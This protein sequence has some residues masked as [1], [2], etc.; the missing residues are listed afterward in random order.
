M[1]ESAVKEADRPG[2]T[3]RRPRRPIWPIVVGAS[4]IVGLLAGGIITLSNTH[5]A[6]LPKAPENLTAAART[7]MP[8]A[9]GAILS[10]VT[11]RW[12]LPE[13]PSATGLQ[14]LRDGTTLPAAAGLLPGTTG[15]VDTDVA[16]GQVHSYAV[17]TTG[18]DGDS[19]PSNGAKATLPLPPLRAAQLRS[20][21]DVR[22]VVDEAT[23]IASLSGITRPV[24]GDS[25]TT[26]WGFQPTCPPALGACPTHWTGRSGLLRPHTG[27]WSGTVS[28][29]DARCP[30]GTR[31]PSPI[32]LVLRPR[33]AAMVGDAW[34]V[35]SFTGTYSVQFHCPGFLVSRGVLDATGRHQ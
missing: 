21:Y 30:D 6:T 11:L 29:P 5:D 2:S 34:S 35:M 14:V 13:D 12:T 26:T 31:V 22:L 27:V 23:N 20:V 9:C 15:F 16:P 28:G 7:C 1:D 4:T 33:E 17:R 10:T 8:P 32:H 18:R 19:P 25:R 3:S 24:P